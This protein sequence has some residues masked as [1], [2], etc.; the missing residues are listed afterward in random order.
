M[1]FTK[2]SFFITILCFLSVQN[3]AM[4]GDFS[5]SLDC[6]V[7]L[8]RLGHQFEETDKT[9]F[10]KNDPIHPLIIKKFVSWVSDDWKPKIVA[11]DVCAAYNTNQFCKKFQ[12]Q[13][14]DDGTFRCCVDEKDGAWFVYEWLGTLDNGLHVVLTC[15]CTGGTGQFMDL[16]F[17]KITE[18]FAY[19]PEGEK[20]AQLLL[21]FVRNHALGDRYD[22]QIDLL[23]NSVCIGK[24][25]YNDKPVFMEFQG[26]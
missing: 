17:F 4:F 23:K 7:T 8:K 3:V 18:G 2:P 5:T 11:I 9:F 25:R 21:T 12:W 15:E 26:K 20:Y 24:S 10:Y 19:T 14:A 16:F 22:G 6:G 13:K 1:E